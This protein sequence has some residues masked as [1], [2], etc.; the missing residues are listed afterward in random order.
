MKIELLGMLACFCGV[1]M[2][3]KDEEKENTHVN[4]DDVSNLDT[5]AR[6]IGIVVMS[7]VAFNDG[8]LAVMARKM[9]TVHFSLIMFWFS[10]VA[11]VMVVFILLVE[12]FIMG[13]IPTIFTYSW[14]QYQSLLLTGVFSAL[15][16]TCLVIAYQN[17]KSATVSLLAYIALV[18]A[19]LAD[20]LMFQTQFTTIELCGAGMIT[21]F[22][23]LTILIKA[24]SSDGVDDDCHPV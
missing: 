16:L 21:F 8:L 9:K 23:L 17:D 19:F 20:C 15:N 24:R 3:A 5:F 22:N 1:L 10:V 2:M 11:I 4:S 6:I 18:Y 13:N 7:W 12:S 14:D